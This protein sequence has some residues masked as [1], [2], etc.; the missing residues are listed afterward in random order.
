MKRQALRLLFLL[1]VAINLGVIAT[2]AWHRYEAAASGP[3]AD[4]AAA[5]AGSLREE[6]RLTDGQVL[7]F[8][9]LYAD[10]D[11]RVAA[12]RARMRDRRRALFEILGAPEADPAALDA[13]LGEI[14]VVQAGIQRAVADYLL[15]Q[16]RLLAPDQRARYVALLQERT[17]T[18]QPTHLPLVGPRGAPRPGDRR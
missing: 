3:G 7:E 2:I 17:R 18:E 16:A 5:R 10:L 14:G 6:L 8:D 1:S 12:G 9:R 13:V 15:A 11:G 4:D